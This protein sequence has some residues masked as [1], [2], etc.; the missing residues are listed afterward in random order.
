MF[1]K[2]ALCRLICLEWKAFKTSQKITINTLEKVVIPTIQT[3]QAFKNLQNYDMKH[4]VL[5][6]NRP[7]SCI[8][9]NFLDVQ[10]LSITIEISIL[11]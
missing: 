5:D 4:T 9:S 3:W 2:F 10:K 8:H 6:D 1:A 7:L 11:V